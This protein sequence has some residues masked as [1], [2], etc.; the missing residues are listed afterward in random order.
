MTITVEAGTAE[1]GGA[2]K[3][4]SGNRLTDRLSMRTRRLIWVWSFLAL[5]ILFYSVIR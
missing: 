1:T 4:P 3:G 2:G 5:P